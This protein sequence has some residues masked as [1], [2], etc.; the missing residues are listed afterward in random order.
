[1]DRRTFINWVGVGFLANYLPVTLAACSSKS[2]TTKGATNDFRTVGTV[3][4]L[5]QDGQILNEQLPQ[6]PVLVVQDSANSNKLVA[7][8]PICTHRDCAVEWKKQKNVFL[9]TCHDSEFDTTGQV[10]GPPAKIPLITYSVKTEGDRIL[11]G[12]TQPA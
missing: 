11:V 12:N 3:A 1:M 2:S 6:T 4:Q 5:E 9:C 8:N 10:L 7:I